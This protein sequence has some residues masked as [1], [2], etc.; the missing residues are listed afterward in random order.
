MEYPKQESATGTTRRATIA[1]RDVVTVY[2]DAAPGGATNP[3]YTQLLGE[4]IPAE[5]LQVSGGEA[6]RGKQVEAGTSY[7]VSV[8]WIHGLRM[9]AR[10]AVEVGSGIYAGQ[11]LYTRRVMVETDRSRPMALQ[12][13]CGT[14]E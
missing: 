1:K 2:Q 9:D 12:L 10:C 14:H 8:A 6:I 11:T 3:Q 13:H 5:V 7:V 4:N